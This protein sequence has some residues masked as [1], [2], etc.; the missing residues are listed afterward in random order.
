MPEIEV[1]TEHLHEALHEHAQG[2]GHGHE[3]GGEDWNRYVALSAALLAVLAAVAALIAG[4]Y[5]N[6]ALLDQIRASNQWNYYQAKS[7]KGYLFEN[8]VD[9]LQGNGRAAS[10][11]DRARIAKYVAEKKEVEV[12]ARAKEVDSKH[13]LHQHHVFARSVTLFQIA[14]ALA[15]ITVLM[16]RRMLWYVSLLF[17]LGGSVFL[18]Q[19]FLT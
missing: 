4:D 12:I 16:R 5:A 10:D 6:E 2:H 7:I 19:G 11:A 1:P 9:I 13:H 18:V 3:G 14:I 17:G 8:K 15:A